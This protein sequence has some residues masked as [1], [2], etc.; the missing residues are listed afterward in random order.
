MFYLDLS[1]SYRWPVGLFVV[2]EDGA[3]EDQSFDAEFARLEQSRVNDLSE[4]IAARMRRMAIG[5]SVDNMITDVAIANEVLIGWHGI[6]D[7]PGG[8]E[9][10]FS[11]SFRARLL[12][13]QGMA[14]AVVEAW[15]ES[16]QRG[17]PKTSKLPL[18][19]G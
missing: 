11:V 16:L 8:K 5:E 7:K 19:S 4:Q 9:V 10:P 2:N 6:Y 14:K 15:I 17:K 13:V 12:N 1:K 3:V 18:G